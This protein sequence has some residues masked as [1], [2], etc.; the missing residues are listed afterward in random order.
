MHAAPTAL[1]LTLG[2]V[3]CDATRAEPDATA[4]AVDTSGADADVEP[5]DATTGLEVETTDARD[6]WP[7]VAPDASDAT[8][9]R[10]PIDALGSEASEV[11]PDDVSDDVPEVGSPC[12]TDARVVVGTVGTGD[13]SGFAALAPGDTLAIVHGVQGGIHVEVALALPDDGLAAGAYDVSI[14]SRVGGVDVGRFVSLGFYFERD[15]DATLTTTM[16]PVIFDTVEAAPFDGVNA[17]V[18]A[19]VT[20]P[21][22]PVT[23]CLAA[24]FEDAP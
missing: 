6:T 8:D 9:A 18:V 19:T 17:E 20:L 22:G 10:D 3:A 24:R 2:L 5:A 14:L 15:A 13:E 21:G 7:E 12:V 23:T 16:V 4:E 1:L 11:G